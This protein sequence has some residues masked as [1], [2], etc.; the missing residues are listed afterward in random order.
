MSSLVRC[1]CRFD[2]VATPDPRLFSSAGLNNLAARWD[3]PLYRVHLSTSRLVR[4]RRKNRVDG[5]SSCGALASAHH[6]LM[7]RASS[8]GKSPT[9]CHVVLHRVDHR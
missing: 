9:V 5:V 7:M 2:I 1:R 4:D 6:S 3:V 8:W